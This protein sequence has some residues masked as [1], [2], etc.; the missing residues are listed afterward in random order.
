MEGK[1]DVGADHEDQL[2]LGIRII[3]SAFQNKMHNLEQEIRG[4]RLTF[5][6]QRTNVSQL[7]KKNSSLEVELV[8]SHQRSQQL[9]EENKELFKTVTSLR[10][11]IG[12]LEH[13]K[14]AVLHSIQDDQQQEAELGDTRMLLSDEFLMGATPLTAAGM[15][16]GGR[17]PIPSTASQ[18]PYGAPGGYAASQAPQEPAASEVGGPAG[19]VIDGKQFFRQARSR[20]SYEAFNQFLASIKR[21]NSQQQTREETLDE[22]RRIFGPE[23][24]DL[25]RDFEGLLNRHGM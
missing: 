14:Q 17:A 9:Q 8:E 12:R 11:Q 10:K 3:T 13:L 16:F 1:G 23:L 18:Q 20:L 21:L 25:Y 6:E 4:F 22:A 5:E 19:G 24:Q 7:Q 2:Q 15:G